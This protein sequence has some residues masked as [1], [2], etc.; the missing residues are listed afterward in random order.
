MFVSEIFHFFGASTY[1]F[2]VRIPEVIK[3]ALNV[4][5]IKPSLSNPPCLYR[6]HKYHPQPRVHILLH[7]FFVFDVTIVDMPNRQILR[8]RDQ[9]SYLINLPFWWLEHSRIATL[10]STFNSI[11]IYFRYLPRYQI[12]RNP[13]TIRYKKGLNKS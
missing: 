13:Y 11:I 5:I 1:K 9:A 7:F 3:R 12:H 6:H 4:R 8:M 2:Q 10:M